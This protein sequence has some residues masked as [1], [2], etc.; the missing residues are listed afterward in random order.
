V[1]KY[2]LSLI[3]LCSGEA[4]QAMGGGESQTDRLLELGAQSAAFE[5]EFKQ[6]ISAGHSDKLKSLMVVADKSE[7]NPLLT[8][9][10]RHSQACEDEAI[11]EGEAIG[12]F[13]RK[14]KWLIVSDGTAIVSGLGTIG[15]TIGM[16][17]IN[18]GIGSAPG[19]CFGVSSIVLAFTGGLRLC[20]CKRA[21]YLRS[22]AAAQKDI[23]RALHGAA[24]KNTEGS[25]SVNGT[26]EN[27]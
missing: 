26:D 17:M 3:V 11:T 22:I 23:K 1:I 14:N 4:I 27:V 15:G 9:L 7:L 5:K 18:G 12:C 6:V 24:D 10:M 16:A 2:F 8:E 13:P 25:V 21:A 19:I 20:L